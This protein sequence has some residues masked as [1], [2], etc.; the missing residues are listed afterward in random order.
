MFSGYGGNRTCLFTVKAYCDHEWSLVQRSLLTQQHPVRHRRRLKWEHASSKTE[1]WYILSKVSVS[2]RDI[3]ALHPLMLTNA[4]HSSLPDENPNAQWMGKN[5]RPWIL[6]HCVFC[7]SPGSLL[8]LL[9]FAS[10]MLM[11]W[12]LSYID[13]QRTIES[14]ISGFFP[15]C[16]TQDTLT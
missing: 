16:I 3:P 4:W 6:F 14:S 2:E 11:S 9:P 8:Q 5:F 12:L 13:L 15:C 10:A 7:H 1:I